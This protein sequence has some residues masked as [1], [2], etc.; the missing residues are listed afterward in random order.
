MIK[1]QAVAA[2]LF[3]LLGAGAGHAADYNFRLHTLVKSPHPYND[4]AA[5]LKSDLEKKSGGRIAVK[6]FDA[7]QLGKDPAVI[8]EMGLGTINLMISTTNNA[9]KQVP[10]YGIFSMPY[11]FSGMDDVMAK[12]GPGTPVEAHFQKVYADRKVGMTLLALGASGTRNLSNSVKPVTSLA[13]IKGFK[14]R[15]PPSTMISKSWAALGT[16]PVSVAWGELYAA[17]QTKVAQALESSL[18]GYTGSKLYEVAPYLAL[19]AHTIQVN[20]ISMSTV[21]WDKLPGDLQKMVLASAIDATRHGVEKAKGYD[22][23][24]VDKLKKEHGVTVTTPDV[25]EFQAVLEPVQ[26]DLAK[27]LDLAEELK[28][29]RGN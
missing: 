10:E 29:I 18:P 17:M 16:L 2:A 25:T 3:A 23:N 8:S 13:D 7:G 21:T 26:T 19:T 11:L 24:L 9:V 20:H 28:L 27:E 1:L 14:M 22:A 4:M 15:T 6:I 5:Y 12:V